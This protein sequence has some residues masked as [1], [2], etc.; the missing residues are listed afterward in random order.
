MTQTDFHT[1]PSRQ[2]PG[3]PSIPMVPTLNRPNR[4]VVG[5]SGRAQVGKQSV[6]SGLV[7]AYSA[8]G[9]L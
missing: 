7:P 5:Q 9:R 6:W 2:A 1:R 8:D 3:E 4:A